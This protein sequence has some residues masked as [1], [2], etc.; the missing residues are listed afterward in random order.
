MNFDNQDFVCLY[1]IIFNTNT[2]YLYW[3]FIEINL[4]DLE[5]NIFFGPKYRISP[6]CNFA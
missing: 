1:I 5:N 3:N 4:N 6:T 2:G